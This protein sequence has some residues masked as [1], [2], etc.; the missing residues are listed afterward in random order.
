MKPITPTEALS[1]NHIP[2]FV[3]EAINNLII[4]NLHG[5]SSTFTEQALIQEILEVGDFNDP[6]CIYKGNWL[7][8][9]EL[10][11]NAGWKVECDVPG[12]NES[13]DVTWAFTPK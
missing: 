10:Y 4:R 5:K 1:G 7:E 13:Y 11:R 6:A 8:F 2:E 9:E 12:F 3:I